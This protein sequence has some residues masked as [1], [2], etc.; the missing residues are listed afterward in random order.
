MTETLSISKCSHLV[1]NTEVANNLW[2]DFG[3][4][5]LMSH[6]TTQ[7]FITKIRNGNFQST[8]KWLQCVVPTLN[9]QKIIANT[10]KHSVIPLLWS[11]QIV[12]H[13]DW[14]SKIGSHLQWKLNSNSSSHAYTRIGQ[15]LDNC[16]YGQQFIRSWSA[17]RLNLMLVSIP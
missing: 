15:G 9:Y 8:W 7:I 11:Q 14:F 1:L 12:W 3:K 2:P 17:C 13:L 6:F 4:S 5:V 10:L 16:A